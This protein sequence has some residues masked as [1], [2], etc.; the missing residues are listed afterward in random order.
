MKRFEDKVVIITGGG[1]GLGFAYAKGFCREGAKVVLAEYNDEYGKKAEAELRE[2]GG[3][4]MFVP[5]NVGKLE[6]VENVVKKTVEKYGTVHIMINN[7]QS[8][9][10]GDK[11]LFLENTTVEHMRLTWETGALGTYMFMHAVLPYMRENKW[12]RI[13][14]TGSAT[15]INGMET[16]TAYGSQKEATRSMTRIA[17]RENGRHG[18]TVNVICPGAFTEAAKLWKSVDPEAY[19]AAVAPQPI[20]HMGDPDTEIAPVVMFLA[21]EDAKFV[22]GQTIGVDGGTTMF[23]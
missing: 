6:D 5:C 23:P 18:I 21:S 19:E 1:A 10:Y 15:G 16:W 12:G 8:T 9:P 20:P 2:A 4:A 22:T 17:A 11:P 14:N 7:A 13:I 3:D